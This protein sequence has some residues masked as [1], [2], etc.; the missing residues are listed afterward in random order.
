MWI[1]YLHK[2]IGSGGFLGGPVVKTSHL[3]GAW[4]QSPVRTTIPHAM[5]YSQKMLKRKKLGVNHLIYRWVE[6]I[7]TIHQGK[8][9]A[10]TVYC[11]ILFL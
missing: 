2:R 7:S 11:M 6:A 8:Q 9:D 5:R 4:I 10:E 3:Q 1:I